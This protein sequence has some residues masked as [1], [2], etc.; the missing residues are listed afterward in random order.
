MAFAIDC[1][2]C[3]SPACCCRGFTYRTDADPQSQVAPAVKFAARVNWSIRYTDHATTTMAI[4]ATPCRAVHYRVCERATHKHTLTADKS[5]MGR[6]CS[7][8]YN[9]SS[10]GFAA[11]SCF[12]CC[13]P[14]GRLHRRRSAVPRYRSAIKAVAALPL[15]LHAALMQHSSDLCR[16]VF[17]RCDTTERARASL[18]RWL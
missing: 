2:A 12:A 17:A 16:A 7:V 9:V 1:I 3:N 15:G 14:T 5:R 11:I 10:R 6:L 13:D 8:N 4:C 18:D